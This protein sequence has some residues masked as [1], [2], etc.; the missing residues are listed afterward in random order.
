V[1]EE[2]ETR[3]ALI[4]G[5]AEYPHPGTLKNPRNDAAAIGQAFERLGF[6][7]TLRIDLSRDDFLGALQEFAGKSDG[8]HM[9]AIYFAG[10]GI[11]VNQQNFLIPTDAKL[12]WATDVEYEAIT[13]HQV[14]TSVDGAREFKLVMLD[15]CRDNPFRTRLRSGGS[16]SIVIGKGLRQIDPGYPD[17]LIA[18]AAQYGTTALDG[19]GNNSPYVEALLSYIETPGLEIVD[20][21][22]AVRD[23]VRQ[24]TDK[25]QTPC[26]YA[27]LGRK[28]IYLIR[29]IPRA[30]SVPTWLKATAAAGLASLVVLKASPLPDIWPP[31]NSE[32]DRISDLKSLADHQGQH[33]ER[34]GEELNSLG[35]IP[36]RVKSGGRLQPVWIKPG[37]GKDLSESF[38]DCWGAKADQNICGP[39]MVVVPPGRF[40]MGSAQDEPMRNDDEDDVAG[41]NGSRV[42]VA[43]KYPFAVGKFEISVAQW[44]AC[45]D[46]GGCRSSRRLNSEKDYQPAVNVSWGDIT[47]EYIPW[48]NTKVSGKADGP[49]RLLT[50]TEWEYAARADTSTPYWFG[51]KIDARQV[52][53]GGPRTKPVN[54]PVAN[55]WGLHHVHGNVWEWVQDRYLDS[56]KGIESDGTSSHGVCEGARVARGG[57]FTNGAADVRSAK[58]LAVAAHLRS[59]DIGF[60][61]ARSLEPRVQALDGPTALATPLSQSN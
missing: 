4:I 9:A 8:A 7:V 58:R 19:K 3:V 22:R 32:R 12:K 25:K 47:D 57:S 53:F 55:G 56:Y 29:P 31:R 50:E 33:A 40:Y 23:D 36:V 44:Q 16:R 13:L 39:A 34:A 24:R 6:D 37:G 18:Y 52:K 21:F 28:K 11:E 26:H 48:L 35:F 17:M 59:G 42:L 15:A 27:S 14:L 45:F 5:N 61:L 30:P 60:R 51:D 10:H 1:A 54:T 38:Q 41:P 49:Y 43:F 46:D 20:L 2:K